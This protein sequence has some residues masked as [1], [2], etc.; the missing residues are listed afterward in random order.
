MLTYHFP[1]LLVM[2]LDRRFAGLNDGLESWLAPIGAS[3][4]FTHVVLPYIETQKVEAQISCVF[5]QGVGDSCL[6]R[7]EV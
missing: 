2:A 6:A 7:F 1:Y 4:M 3:A 5:V